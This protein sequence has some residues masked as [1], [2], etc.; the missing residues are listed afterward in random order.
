MPGHLLAGPRGR[1]L[2]PPR[3]IAI[4]DTSLAF[5]GFQRDATHLAIG[6]SQLGLRVDLLLARKDLEECYWE[7]PSSVATIELG[8]KRAAHALAPLTAYLRQR[9][10]EVLISTS[11][12]TNLI[13]LIARGLARAR[14][15]LV[16]RE[17]TVASIHRDRRLRGRVVVFLAKRL[18]SRVDSL[19]AVSAGVQEDLTAYMGLPRSS[20]HV[21]HNPSVTP[22][23]LQKAAEPVNHEWLHGNGPPVIISAGRLHW[24]K[25]FPLLLRAFSLVRQERPARLM[26]L[27]EG[28]ERPRLEALARE[29]DII[30]DFALPGFVANPY[31]Y[32]AAASVLALSSTAEAFGHVLVEAMACGTP[33]VSTDCPG[34]PAEILERGRF[35]ALVPVGDAEAMAGAVLATLD[36][37]P[38]RAFLQERA[39][40]F[41]CDR[42]ARDYMELSAFRDRT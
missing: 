19:V 37:P 3:H 16:A 28:E 6:F 24:H 34:G 18:Y 21:I 20:I 33:V 31:N 12:E 40:R 13:A 25:D 8:V 38:R 39:L 36:N 17:A 5:A 15:R 10:P 26:I 30:E 1:E 35:G 42:I 11:T 29:L 7:V 2:E 41:S 22:G 14:T 32:L 23:M 9:R 27:G 4:L